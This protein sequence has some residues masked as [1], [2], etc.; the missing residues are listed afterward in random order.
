MAESV[1]TV[2]LLTE[3]VDSDDEKP[4]RGKTRNWIRRRRDRG[5]FNNIIKELR[6]EDRFGFRDMFRMDIVDFEY[7]LGQIS[8]LISPKEIIG[9]EAT[10]PCIV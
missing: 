3:L 4:H 8:D 9:Y 7:I 2:F 10:P 1:A 5:Y 6:L